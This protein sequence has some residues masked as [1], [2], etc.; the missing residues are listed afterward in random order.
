MSATRLIGSSEP[1]TTTED[2]TELVTYKGPNDD[3]T[4]PVKFHSF[5]ITVFNDTKIN[6]NGGGSVYIPANT[7]LTFKD[8]E[9]DINSCVVEG[10]GTKLVWIATI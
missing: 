10:K 8:G 6:V 1:I 9:I 3:W 7:S 4:L 2:K 5:S